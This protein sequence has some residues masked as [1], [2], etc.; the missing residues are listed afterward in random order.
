MPSRKI[1]PEVG[2][3]SGHPATYVGIYVAY[4]VAWDVGGLHNRVY[5]RCCRCRYMKKSSLLSAE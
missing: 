1:T 3:P 2:T 4:D 5:A